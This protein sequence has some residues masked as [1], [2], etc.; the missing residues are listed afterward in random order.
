MRI[1]PKLTLADSHGLV[2]RPNFETDWPD[3]DAQRLIDAG[4]ATRVPLKQEVALDLLKTFGAGLVVR[5]AT[6]PELVR[7]AKERKIFLRY[8][9]KQ[10]RKKNAP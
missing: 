1:L 10:S 6:D 2:A 4:Y 3:E 8:E 5:P 9:K 7:Q